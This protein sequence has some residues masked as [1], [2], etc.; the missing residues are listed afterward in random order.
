LYIIRRRQ[1]HAHSLCL[2]VLRSQFDT[3][4][5]DHQSVRSRGAKGDNAEMDMT[6]YRYEPPPAGYVIKTKDGH[7]LRPTAV[8]LAFRCTAQKAGPP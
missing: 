6:V 1:S 3:F 2:S 5:A 7:T 4:T 8:N